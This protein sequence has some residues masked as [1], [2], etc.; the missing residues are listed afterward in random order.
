MN[1]SNLEQLLKYPASKDKLCLC[2]FG[3]LVKYFVSQY[4]Y[5]RFCRFVFTQITSSSATTS[6]RGKQHSVPLENGN[7]VHFNKDTY[8]RAI[9]FEIHGLAA[10]T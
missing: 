1:I 8:I 3:S 2:L 10:T 4:N 6:V 7:Y 9:H 5:K